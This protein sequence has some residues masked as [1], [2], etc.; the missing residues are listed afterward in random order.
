MVAGYAPPVLAEAINTSPVPV[1]F[2]RGNCDS[3]VDQ[4]VINYPI[5]SPYAFVQMEGVRILVNHGEEVSREEMVEQAERH[6]VDIFIFGHVHTPILEKHGPVFLLNPGSPALPKS[7]P[8][9]VGLIDISSRAILLINLT[10]SAVLQQ[11]QF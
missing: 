11:A 7:P 3:A 9:T 1:I 10:T 8:P 4:L 2:A 6:K 5:Q